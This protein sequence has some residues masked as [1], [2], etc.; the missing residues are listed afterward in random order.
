MQAGGPLIPI[1][2]L[3]DGTTVEQVP[4]DSVEYYVELPAH[5]VMLAE[6]VPVESYLDTGNRGSFLV[7]GATAPIRTPQSTNSSRT[8]IPLISSLN[9]ARQWPTTPLRKNDPSSTVPAARPCVSAAN[10][11]M[12]T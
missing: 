6:G 10:L 2:H 4:T 1:R 3:V 7:R 9:V 8:I 11:P 12:R 5:D